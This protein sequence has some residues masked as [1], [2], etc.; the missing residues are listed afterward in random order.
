MEDI[1]M[2]N[3]RSTWRGEFMWGTLRF[4]VLFCLWLWYFWPEI[5]RMWSSTLSTSETAH[6][7]VMPLAIVLLVFLRLPAIATRMTGGSFFGVILIIAGLAIYAVTTWPFYYGYVRTMTMLPVLGG[8]V[9]AACGWRVFKLSLPLLLL[10]M[11]SIEIGT[12]IYARLTILPETYTIA[13][14]AGV[15]DELPGVDIIVHG[16][17]VLFTYG[18]KSGVIGLGQSYRGVRLFSA[19]ALL[20]VFVTFCRTR[21]TW[22][23]A[24]VALA[25]LPILLLCNFLRFFTWGITAIYISGD[26]AGI[27]PR[28]VSA[29]VSIVAA[30]CLFVLVCEFKLN[31]FVDVN[32]EIASFDGEEICHE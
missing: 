2:L 20:G 14:V 11:L 21:S 30:Y 17:D 3:S 6:I 23:L 15:L 4:A 28:N 32:E 10:I 13:A 5:D 1:I 18:E 31:L 8:V 12:A 29:I 25:A 26:S 24:L 9:W 16:V 19:F 22:R 27:M 7:L